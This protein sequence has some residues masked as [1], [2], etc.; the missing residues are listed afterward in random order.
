MK[1]RVRASEFFVELLFISCNL[2]GLLFAIDEFTDVESR[3]VVQEIVDIV[4]DALHSPHKPRPREEIIL[5]EMT[6][7]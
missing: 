7:Q 3:P 5:G 6:R 2:M 4:I 1:I